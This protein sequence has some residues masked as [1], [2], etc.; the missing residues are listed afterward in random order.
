MGRKII[1]NYF[2]PFSASLCCEALW[3]SWRLASEAEK[4]TFSFGLRYWQLESEMEMW[5]WFQLDSNKTLCNQPLHINNIHFHLRL[6]KQFFLCVIF[7]SWSTF[8]IFREPFI[9]LLFYDII[10]YY[11]LIMALFLN[12]IF[13]MITSY[14]QLEFRR[15]TTLFLLTFL[16]HP[17]LGQFKVYLFI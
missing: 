9:H 4:E 13:I 6:P 11:I 16:P 15:K 17:F 14:N 3:L 7:R 12:K 2:L 1:N 10:L 5:T 8:K